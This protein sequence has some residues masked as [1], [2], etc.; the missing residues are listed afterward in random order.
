M[1]SPLLPHLTP[2]APA[3]STAH[4]LDI[5]QPYL[6]SHAPPQ[7]GFDVSDL[8]L[9]DPVAHGDFIPYNLH[10]NQHDPLT[11]FLSQSVAGNEKTEAERIGADRF[12]VSWPML[13]A[14]RLHSGDRHVIKAVMRR[15][16]AESR[17]GRVFT[18]LEIPQDPDT[19]YRVPV[20]AY[21]N[22]HGGRH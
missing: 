18:P 13:R 16:Y 20:D 4:A 5:R 1:Q 9:H 10:S 8:Q 12:G 3:P 21:G 22:A 7:S 19:L 14:Q 11:A 15:G 17:I 6:L 2:P